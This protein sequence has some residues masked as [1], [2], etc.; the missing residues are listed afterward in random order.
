MFFSLLT[1]GKF[2]KSNF[3]VLVW[4]S[5]V[6]VFRRL[7][8]FENQ[9][10]FARLVFC[11][12]TIG[13]FRPATGPLVRIVYYLHDFASSGVRKLYYLN[14]FVVSGVRV[15]Y[16]LHDFAMV[17]ENCAPMT[18][19]KTVSAPERRRACARRS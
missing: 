6:L 2:G 11:V 13:K 4:C 8:N 3:S 7:V 10:F 19:L 18:G 14:D 1:T 17:N 9:F 15:M 12:L 16:Y 5:G